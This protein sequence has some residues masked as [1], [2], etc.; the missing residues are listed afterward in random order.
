M[1]TYQNSDINKMNLVLFEF[2]DKVSKEEFENFKSDFDN[3]LKINKPF[4]AI[5]NLL[6]I[7]D[8]DIK[9][10]Y[11]KMDYIYKNKDKV[12]Q[13]LIASSIVIKESYGKLIKFGLK[14]K[15]PIS[16]NIVCDDLNKGEE[17]LKTFQSSINLDINK[18]N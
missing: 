3:L 10:F 12:K 6:G 5:F 4:F 8:F 2:A 9:F 18:G 14:L 7:K 1:Y 13:L 16:P 17:F 15:K 11:K